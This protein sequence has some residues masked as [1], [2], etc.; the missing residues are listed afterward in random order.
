MQ[1]GKTKSGAW[2]INFRLNFHRVY[3][4]GRVFT[5]AYDSQLDSYNNLIFCHDLSS[6]FSEH[7]FLCA[8][9]VVEVMGR[10]KDSRAHDGP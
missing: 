5:G 1:K 8:P 2:S 9:M 4:F 3:P 7:S 10:R 6:C